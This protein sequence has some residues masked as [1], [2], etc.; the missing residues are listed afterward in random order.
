PRDGTI[1]IW[2][3]PLA[4]CAEA[5]KLDGVLSSD[6][7]SRAA[8]FRFV[9]DGMRF[10]L[11]HAA[12]RI[13]LGHYLGQPASELV[14]TTGAWGKPR[15]G[16]ESALRF[17]LAHSEDL[18]VMAFTTVGEVGVD[19]EAVA[20]NIP[21]E[22][23]AKAHFTSQEAA[24]VRQPRSI[25]TQARTFLRLW[26]RKEAIFK[27]V[28]CG[29]FSALDSIDVAAQSN[30]VSV[31]TGLDG[32]VNSRWRLEDLELGPDF[33]GVVA[34]P[35]GEWTVVQWPVSNTRVAMSLPWFLRSSMDSSIA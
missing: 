31:G 6:E 2:T 14:F 35:A 12:L 27:G 17:N 25:E 7:R 28:G 22:S 19:L 11:C 20:A 33:I 30:V 21:A 32:G 26:T 9:R 29:L 24:L 4:S 13:A 3:V 1:D 15:L 5:A 18:T 10:R 23:I 8:R 34:A 16:A